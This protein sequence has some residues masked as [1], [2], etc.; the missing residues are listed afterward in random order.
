MINIS[1]MI[2]FKL[3]KVLEDDSVHI[4]RIVKAKKYKDGGSPAEITIQD[5][6][7]LKKVRVDSLKDYTPLEPDGIIT[8]NIVNISDKSGNKAKNYK[9]VIV[10][11]SKMLNVKIGDTLPWAVCRQ[12][13]TDLFYNL[14]VKNENDMMAGLAINQ[15]NCPAN[16]DYG[17]M[18]ACDGIE[19]SELINFYRTDTLED[20]YPMIKMSKYDEVLK[21]LYKMHVATI[22]DPAAIF[23][24][25]DKGW[26]R[27]LK[28]LLT[29]NNFQSDINE[30]LGISDVMFDMSKYFVT[31]ELPGGEEYTSVN[32]E[33]KE[34]LSHI[35]RV[36]IDD[37]TAIEYDHDINLGEFNNAKYFI[38]RDN[39]K[40]LYLMVYTS[41][42][43]YLGSD[44]EAKAAKKDFSSEFRL[45]F[46]NKYN[47]I[48]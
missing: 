33:L 36:N 18:L 46:Y 16:Y 37:I 13:I 45:S 10:T 25:N 27:D 8:F 4:V 26:C 41:E 39:T 35:Y 40:K 5:G 15:N 3:F 38:V 9:D 21:D 31:K 19:F 47:H 14:L 30:M 1:T 48:K 7:E 24:K 20:I 17:I 6:D 29:Q 22:D 32:E 28:T 11:A 42:G 43:E 23:K 34:W 2:G 44:L 12:N